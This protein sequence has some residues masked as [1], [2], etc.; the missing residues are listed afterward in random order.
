MAIVRAGQTWRTDQGAS[1]YVDEVQEGRV[2]GT[3]ISDVAPNA[4]SAATLP[5]TAFVRYELLEDAEP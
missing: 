5:L 1:L 4:F 3:L 2:V